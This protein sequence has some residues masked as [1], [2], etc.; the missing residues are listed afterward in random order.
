[1]GNPFRGKAFWRQLDEWNARLAASGLRDVERSDGGLHYGGNALR[2]GARRALRSGR[3]EYFRRAGQWAHDR[4]FKTRT[5]RRVWELHA[6]GH[7]HREIAKLLG[8]MRMHQPRRV[9]EVIQRERAAMVSY[10][11]SLP[12]EREELSL[13]QQHLEA[14]HYGVDYDYASGLTALGDPM[15]RIHRALE[16][17]YIP[18]RGDG[19][20]FSRLVTG[21]ARRAVFE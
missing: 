21:Q 13:H 18:V 15:R 16:R 19:A 2:R 6:E 17:S 8:P 9:L 12:L 3:G 4:S 10:Y 1:M 11:A 14:E 20:R 7:G 5:Q